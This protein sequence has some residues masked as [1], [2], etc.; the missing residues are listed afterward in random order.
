MASTVVYNPLPP[1]LHVLPHCKAQSFV[2]KKI[3]RIW[4]AFLGIWYETLPME[5]W[6]ALKMMC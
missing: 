3:Q 4:H 5:H 6:F 1:I 2:L